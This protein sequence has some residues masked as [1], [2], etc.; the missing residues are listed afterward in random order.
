MPDAAA[1]FAAAAGGKTAELHGLLLQAA[2]EGEAVAPDLVGPRASEGG[3]TPLHAAVF[4]DSR[5]CAQLLVGAR[6]DVNARESSGATPLSIAAA[7]GSTSCLSTLIAMGA[8]LDLADTSGATP[9]HAS[10][11]TGHVECARLLLGANAE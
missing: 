2:P 11:S 1:V 5:V 3:L 8:T 7:V 9:L 10:C 4:A 6:A